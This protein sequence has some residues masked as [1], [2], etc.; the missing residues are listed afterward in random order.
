MGVS[1]EKA[2]DK[3]IW[4]FKPDQASARDINSVACLTHVVFYLSFAAFSL[5]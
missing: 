1:H 2:S 3:Y 4:G 5:I